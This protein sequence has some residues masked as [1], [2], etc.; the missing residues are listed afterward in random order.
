MKIHPSSKK[1]YAAGSRKALLDAGLIKQADL[2]P[3]ELL[4]AEALVGGGP[5]ISAI[6]APEDRGASRFGHTALGG[7]L[8]AGAGAGVG[9][10]A[11]MGIGKLLTLLGSRGRVKPRLTL[12]PQPS[13]KGIG[14]EAAI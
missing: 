9:L 6:A 3:S 7:L 12:R 2:S 5:I 14:L 4:W 1:A 8:G 10:G 11:G 13:F